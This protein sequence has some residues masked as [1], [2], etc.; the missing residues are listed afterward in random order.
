MLLL[1]FWPLVP[2]Y[3]ARCHDGSDE[4]LG[5]VLL[6]CAL[7]LWRRRHHCIE[8]HPAGLAMA[9]T[10]SLAVCLSHAW[11]PPIIEGSLAVL[12]IALASGL[13]RTAP[14]A[15]MLMM[16]SLPWSASLQFFLGFP[17]RW[18]SAS[19]AAALLR[20]VGIDVVRSGTDLLTEHGLPVGVDPPCSGVHMLWTGLVVTAILA[21][22]RRLAGGRFVAALVACGL[23]VVIG[24][25]LRSGLLFLPESGLTPM[26]HWTHEA[27]GLVVF[28]LALL[29]LIS[30]LNALAGGPS[31]STHKPMAQSFV[32]PASVLWLSI[33]FGACG[34]LARYNEPVRERFHEP[35]SKLTAMRVE[36]LPRLGLPESVDGDS[37]ASQNLTDRER[38]F[39]ASFPGTLQ[40]FAG[41]QAEVIVRRVSRP[42]RMLHS[43]SDCLTASGFE[44]QPQP[45]FI[46]AQ[47][48]AWHRCTAIRSRERFCMLERILSADGQQWSDTSAWF[49]NAFFQQ[50][51]GPWTAITVLLSK[52]A[53]GADEMAAP[54]STTIS[55]FITSQWP[56]KEQM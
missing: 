52:P 54:H 8:I 30:L 12:V 28:A 40:R 31:K 21:E 33:T 27:V 25:A 46:D 5:P 39:A 47:G 7:V 29:S 34:A 19:L 55:P 37:L 23:L 1:P 43:S 20:C 38:A 9:T 2:W 3:V 50:S 56:G 48:N 51:K 49:W 41:P 32:V 11:L 16:F 4:P 18:L 44:V 42:T 22:Q 36:D 35:T 10:I 17:M 6:A 14:G 24:N 13:W 15:L 26:P 45:V 53:A